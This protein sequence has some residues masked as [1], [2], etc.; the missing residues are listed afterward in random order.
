MYNIY[1]S[2]QSDDETYFYFPGQSLLQSCVKQPI[3][4]EKKP[5]SDLKDLIL[6]FSYRP[7]LSF[8]GLSKLLY[9]SDQNIAQ[10]CALSLQKWFEITLTSWTSH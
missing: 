3:S 6:F 5:K 8:Q 9:D 7:I 10:I 2:D 4:P 1:L